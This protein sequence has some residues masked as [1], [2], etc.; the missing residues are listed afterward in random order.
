MKHTLIIYILFFAFIG[1]QVIH[2]YRASNSNGVMSFGNV[3]YILNPQMNQYFLRYSLDKN[4]EHNLE[5]IKRV[6]ESELNIYTNE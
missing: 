1:W 2:R 4:D 3:L 6:I 5:S